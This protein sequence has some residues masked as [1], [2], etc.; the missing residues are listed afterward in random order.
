MKLAIFSDV[1]GNAFALEAALNAMKKH[2]PDYYFCLGD[3]VTGAQ[4]RKTLDLLQSV[5]CWTVQGNMD[6]VILNPVKYTGDD[7]TERR[8]NDIDFWVHD[9]L[10]GEDFTYLMDLYG[11]ISWGGESEKLF[12][13]HGSP[14]SYNDVIDAGT[15]DED[16]SE[17][18]K[19]VDAAFLAVG[20]MHTP[21]LRIFNEMTIF[22]PGSVGLPY[23]AHR[24][25][26]C[27]ARYVIL[28]MGD[29]FLQCDI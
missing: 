18:L 11:H 13:V 8:Y 12:C 29:S 21:M 7:E 5:K 27:V 4:P 16:L 9:Q 22:N 15:S 19:G 2:S 6:E 24:P 23:G 20:H 14:R 26:P 25:M 1:H 17:M 28:K 3:L 10:T